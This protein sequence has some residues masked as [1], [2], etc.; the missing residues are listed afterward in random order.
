M[1][2]LRKI[3]V[4]APYNANN[5]L[6]IANV[7]KAITDAGFDVI[8]LKDLLKNPFLLFKCKLFN[9]NWFEACNSKIDY[10]KKALTL[11]VLHV[12][13]KKIVYTLHNGCPQELVGWEN[14]M[15]TRKYIKIGLKRCFCVE[16]VV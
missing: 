16:A 11:R 5:N 1:R 2:K 6:Y 10:I 8:S 4:L 12:L 13:G 9:F 15:M 7:R 14:G 3:T